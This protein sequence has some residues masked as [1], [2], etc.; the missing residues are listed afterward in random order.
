LILAANSKMPP[1]GAVVSKSLVI[2]GFVFRPQV[3]L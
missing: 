1:W 3:F 2:N